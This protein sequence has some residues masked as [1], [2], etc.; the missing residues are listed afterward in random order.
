[1]GIVVSSTGIWMSDKASLALVATS[2]G[3]IC[4]NRGDAKVGGVVTFDV[5][6]VFIFSA[7]S[8]L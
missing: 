8:M 5:V 4:C 2:N 7:V 6:T 1:M 3:G